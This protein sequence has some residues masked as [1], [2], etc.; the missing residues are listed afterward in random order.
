MKLI[1]CSTEFFFTVS[2]SNES[3]LPTQSFRIPTF[4]CSNDIY[5]L[6][7]ENLNI[8]YGTSVYAANTGSN[9]ISS[10]YISFSGKLYFIP[11]ANTPTGKAPADLIVR[12][13][14]HYVYNINGT[15]HTLGEFKR[16]ALGSLNNISHVSSIPQ[17]AAGMVAY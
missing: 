4:Y 16:A 5:I 11:W 7:V 14:N 13:D 8:F 1:W 2:P 10:Y 12:A 15:S 17:F 6:Q 9:T 3:H